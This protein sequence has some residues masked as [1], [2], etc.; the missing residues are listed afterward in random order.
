MHEDIWPI[1]PGM[2]EAKAAIE[3]VKQILV[4][5]DR[6]KPMVMQFSRQERRRDRTGRICSCGRRVMTA[7]ETTCWRCRQ[8]RAR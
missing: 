3:R 8:G 4:A 7:G 5:E 1:P 6:R 2:P